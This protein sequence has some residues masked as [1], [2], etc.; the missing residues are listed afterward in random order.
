MGDARL[1]A[2][3]RSRDV[4]AARRDAAGRRHGDHGRSDRRQG[5]RDARGVGPD[6][7]GRSSRR[8]HGPTRACS[9]RWPAATSRAQ[10]CA[11]RRSSAS[12]PADPPQA[13]AGPQCCTGPCIRARLL[14]GHRTFG[15][16]STAS[17]QPGGAAGPRA[18]LGLGAAIVVVLLALT[19]TVGIGILRGAS[20]PIESVTIDDGDDTDAAL[21]ASVFVHVSGAVAAP[22]LYVL[23]AD[24][25]VVDAMAA[26]GGFA[27]GA[28]EAA[29]N[30]A[31]PISD[32]EQLHVP[33]TG[34]APAA[35]TATADP[36]PGDG[37]V[38]LNTA[39]GRRARH[40]SAHRPRDGPADHR[41]ARRERTVHE[42]RGPA[43]RARDRRQ[44]ARDA[45]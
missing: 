35:G 43:R 28:D 5:A 25:R 13:G 8:W 18:R 30:L 7:S 45:P 24:A 33:A 26:A 12:A 34:E 6:R 37:R 16:V 36:A 10:S 3:R 40:P 19:V 42:R 21:P 27:P 9:V 39:R 23:G 38:N 41:M 20:A 4:A 32:G 31:R 29:V 1:R 17:D 22:G 44:D 2:V 14:S 15:R 11:R